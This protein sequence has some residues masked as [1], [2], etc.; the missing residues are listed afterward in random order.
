MPS[1]RSRT[2]TTR[3]VSSTSRTAT[4]PRTP[5]GEA[6][7]HDE[8]RRKRPDV[9][10]RV[11]A[12][13]SSRAAPA[14]SRRSLLSVSSSSAS[15][16]A[17]A[18]LAVARSRW[19][20]VASESRPA[21][22]RRGA[23]RNAMSSA[24]TH[25]RAR[26]ALSDQRR[27]AGRWPLVQRS[28]PVPHDGA[29]LADQRH[30]VGDGPER[31][32]LQQGRLEPGSGG[33]LEPALGQ[34]LRHLERDA[35]AG[36]LFERVRAV[37]AVRVDDRNGSRELGGHV[38][39][40]G[41]DDVQADRVGRRDLGRRRHATVDGDD[42]PGLLLGEDAQDVRVEAVA[43]AVAVRDE[44]LGRRAERQQRPL[45]DRRSAQT[46]DVVVAVDD[47]LLAGDRRRAR[48]GG[49]PPPG[50][51][52]ARVRATGRGGSMNA[53]ASSG[54]V[55]PRLRSNCASSGWPTP[56]AS[57]SA[58]LARR[59]RVQERRRLAATVTI[60]RDAPELAG[61]AA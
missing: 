2:A 13:A 35:G 28:Q 37:G 50:R 33:R 56:S 27:E 17:S 20:I 42:Q 9:G 7:L 5:D 44:H 26:P 48:C 14:R 16:S 53:R 11:V 47:D 8:R 36:K 10:R 6:R 38:V 19:V 15:C 25:G 43:V 58:R 39:V 57:S 29:V 59:R 52:C 1:V 31:R 60:G 51:P 22:F 12:R 24:S 32:E 46:V 61:C 41:D 3:P 45:E 21:A 55:T 4:R 49:R 30:D 23:S 40:I 34:R 18:A 54:E